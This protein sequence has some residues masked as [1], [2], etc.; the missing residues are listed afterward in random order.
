MANNRFGFLYNFFGKK[1]EKVQNPIKTEVGTF[2]ELENDGSFTTFD[3]YSQDRP[4]AQRSINLNIT[5][6][7]AAS[8]DRKRKIK[9]YRKM[10]LSNEVSKA[11]EAVVNECIVVEN[12][13]AI[14]E[15]NLEESNIKDEMKETVKEEF[16][17]ILKLLNFRTMGQD[18]FKNF[19]IEGEIYYEIC[20]NKK[21][22]KDGIKRFN[23]IDA[24]KVTKIKRVLQETDAE[25]GQTVSK[26]VKRYFL[27]QPMN[28]N[29]KASNSTYNTAQNQNILFNEHNLLYAWSGIIDFERDVVLSHLEKAAKPYNQLKLMEDSLIIYR[30]ARAPE[31]RVFYIDVGN[32]PK[33]KAEGYIRR[34][35]STYKNKITYDG[36]T[37]SLKDTTNQMMMQDD[38]W[39]PRS[40][41]KGTEVSNLQGGQNLGEV[42]DV[43]FFKRNLNESL[44][45]PLSRLE[46]DSG[47]VLGRASEI[48]RDELNFKKFTDGLREK[49]IEIFK[50][51]L[52][53]QLILKGLTTAAE[54]ETI[55]DDIMFDFTND[56]YFTELKS[57]EISR[58][59]ISLLTEMIDYRGVYYSN[60]WLRKNV[61]FQTDEEIAEN[62]KQIKAEKDVEQFDKPL[63][64]EENPED[65]F[66]GEGGFGD[67]ED[68]GGDGGGFPSKKNDDKEGDEEKERPDNDNSAPKFPDKSKFGIG[69]K[70]KK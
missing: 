32:M 62:D 28:D 46:P 42:E 52:R 5:Q 58:E 9:I 50:Q 27:Y 57:L 23:K 29:K 43:E 16:E 53:I 60:D 45:I 25:T 3:Y 63:G 51:A 15:L 26:G 48:S 8:S 68:D 37:G 4:D 11:I 34:I 19:Y 59:R 6:S 20:I 24:A 33:S 21:K 10:A 22:P 1:E 55:K 61:L 2:S 14:V 66:G 49:F 17:K 41:G 44:N 69:S 65:E 39:L 70:N 64:N 67:E 54:W 35:M 38:F 13:K 47:N 36:N 56:S 31:R 30:L 40:D 7:T 12:R 18:M